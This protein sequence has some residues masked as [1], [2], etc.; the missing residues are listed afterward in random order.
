MTWLEQFL[1]DPERTYAAQT[2]ARTLDHGVGQEAEYVMNLP[3]ENLRKIAVFLSELRADPGSALAPMPP[4]ERSGFIDEMVK[5]WAP[6][7]WKEKYQDIRE[8]QPAAAPNEEAGGTHG[9]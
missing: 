6:P 8:R 2:G 1:K 5:T 4:P 3:P 9:H 7:E